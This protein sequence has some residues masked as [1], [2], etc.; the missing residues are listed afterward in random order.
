MNLRIRKALIAIAGA[1]VLGAGMAAPAMASPSAPAVTHVATPNPNVAVGYFFLTNSSSYG[2]T[3]HGLGN[4]LTIQNS[5][6][7]AFYLVAAN[8]AGYYKY[9]VDGADTHCLTDS[10]T[11]LTIQT[12]AQGATNQWFAATNPPGCNFNSWAN[13]SR[14]VVVYDNVNGKPIWDDNNGGGWRQWS[15]GIFPTC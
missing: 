5:G 15:S 11:A 1:A 14:T 3:T 8:P 6:Q 10:N 4:Q 7:T 13:P 12:C 2:W 9:H